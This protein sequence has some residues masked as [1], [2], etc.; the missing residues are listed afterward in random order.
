[1]RAADI[2]EGAAH[3][4]FN[5][6]AYDAERV[7]VDQIGFGDDGDAAR[8][9]EQPADFKVLAGLRL[10]GFVGSDNQEHQVHAAD[11]GQHVADKTFMARYVYETKPELGFIFVASLQTACDF[12][13]FNRVLRLMRSRSPRGRALTPPRENRACRGP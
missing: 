7:F 12:R 3:K 2:K 11:A 4:I 5:L 6:H 8:N 10:D 1:R 13:R 9:R